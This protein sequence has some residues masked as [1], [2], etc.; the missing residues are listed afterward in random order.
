VSIG[1]NGDFVSRIPILKSPVF[2]EEKRTGKTQEFFQNNMV[3]F[4]L[5]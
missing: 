2:Q 1:F 3:A 5:C 4:R